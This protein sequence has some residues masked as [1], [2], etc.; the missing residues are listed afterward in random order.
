MPTVEEAK[1][2]LIEWGEKAPV[3]GVAGAPMSNPWMKVGIAAAGGVLVAVVLK[4]G[5]KR[6]GGRVI[7]ASLE[8]AA[9]TITATL[10]PF[11]VKHAMESF[12]KA[13]NT[14]NGSTDVGSPPATGEA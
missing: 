12:T 9:A 11:L 5:G 4:Q 6:W 8:R 1:A 10:V 3:P 13:T 14:G 7:G 2:K